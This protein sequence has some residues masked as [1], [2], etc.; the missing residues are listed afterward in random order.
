MFATMGL[1]K[2]A[3]S[4]YKTMGG[5]FQNEDYPS[6]FPSIDQKSIDRMVFLHFKFL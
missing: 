5:A 6:R 1:F 2:Q 4:R 3:V